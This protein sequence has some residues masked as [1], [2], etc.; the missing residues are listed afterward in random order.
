MILQI[1]DETKG[2][3]ENIKERPPGSNFLDLRWYDLLLRIENES[4]VVM[5]PDLVS[6]SDRSPMTGYLVKQKGS[7]ECSLSSP[8]GQ[9]L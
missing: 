7:S 2:L 1:V 5:F 9:C 8:C 6:I 3:G 4:G